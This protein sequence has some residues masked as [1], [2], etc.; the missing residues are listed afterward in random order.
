MDKC[1]E[2]GGEI[3]TLVHSVYR[4]DGG[5]S[6]VYSCRGCGKTKQWYKKGY[7]EKDSIID[8]SDDN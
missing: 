5:S 2:C 7:N 4:T 3:L 1:S 6:G 8:M